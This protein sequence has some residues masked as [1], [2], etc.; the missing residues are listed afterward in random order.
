MAR[1][2]PDEQAESLLR[3]AAVPSLATHPG[4]FFGTGHLTL[5]IMIVPPSSPR[6][7]VCVLT[8]CI[9]A[10]FP[11]FPSFSFGN[12]VLAACMGKGGRETFAATR[13]E[14][15]RVE[16]DLRIPPRPGDVGVVSSCSGTRAERDGVDAEAGSP[17]AEERVVRVDG[18]G[19]AMSRVGVDWRDER[20]TGGAGDLEA[21]RVLGIVCVCLVRACRAV[22]RWPRQSSS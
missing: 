2:P 14:R 8:L 20:R 3:L 16:A 19:E 5:A 7:S 4:T 10:A 11:P 9:L 13:G 18:G 22:A 6:C 1:S 21:R 15:A 12:S 17:T